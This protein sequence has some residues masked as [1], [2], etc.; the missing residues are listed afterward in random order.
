MTNDL[1]ILILILPFAFAIH[2][3]EEIFGMEKWTKSIPSFIHSPVTT[4]QFGIAVGLFTFLGFAIIF[5]R[6]FYPTE[7]LYLLVVTSFAGM[8][9]LNVFFPHLIATIYLKKYAPGI[10]S[11]LLINIP[12]TTLIFI[13]IVNLEK[14]TVIEI[15]FSA[16]IGGL[17][18][19]ALAF[20]F[21]KI[22]KILTERKTETTK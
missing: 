8:L 15:C 19:I 9:F 17:I 14:L 6:N 22:G 16:I 13:T 4:K 12:L 10:V 11:G 18:G 3:L 21:L 1:D 5:T 20:T 2:N 7:K